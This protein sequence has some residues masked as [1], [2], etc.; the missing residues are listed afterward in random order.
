[1]VSPSKT[2]VGN[3]TSS[4]PKVASTF[5]ES[6]GDALIGHQRDRERRVQQRPAANSVWAA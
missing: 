6:V 5:W 1:M 3:L 4:Q 2:G